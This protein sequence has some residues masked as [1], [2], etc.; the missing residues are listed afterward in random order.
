MTE[1]YKQTNSVG[2]DQKGKK[3]KLLPKPK[4]FLNKKALIVAIIAGVV[5]AGIAVFW[6]DRARTTPMGIRQSQ[7]EKAQAET[8]E[9]Q[10]MQRELNEKY[11]EWEIDIIKNQLDFY[12]ET[13]G[14]RP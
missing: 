4:A 13:Y 6:I 7:L 12:F 1:N 2:E 8:R 11:P 9:L 14:N 10:K 5:V 3:R